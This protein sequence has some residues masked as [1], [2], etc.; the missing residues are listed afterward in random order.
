MKNTA[1]HAPECRTQWGAGHGTFKRRER[2]L[3]LALLVRDDPKEEVTKWI[4]RVIRAKS[5]EEVRRY[6]QL[7]LP[8][9][10][11]SS[12]QDYIVRHVVN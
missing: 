12:T 11:Q 9:Q 1:E 3:Q 2:R 7:A 4:G 6:F 5:F 10:V 8:L